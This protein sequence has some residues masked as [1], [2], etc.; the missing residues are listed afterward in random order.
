MPSRSAKRAPR[1]RSIEALQ[2][3][4]PEHRILLTGMTPTGREAGREVYGDRVI[5]AYLPY[6]YPDAVDRFFRH[7]SP[8]FG[9]L[10]ETEIWPNLL[11]AAK[12]K[13]VPVIL[14]NARLSERSARGYG[15]VTALAASGLFGARVPW[16]RRRPVD[17]RRIAELGAI[18]VNVCGNLKFDVTPAPEKIALGQAW[19]QAL[20][21][22][23]GLARRQHPR[24]RRSTGARGVAQALPPAV[25]CRFRCWSLCRAT[26]NAFAEVA[27]LL[28]QRRYRLRAA[29]RR[30]A[31]QR[32]AGL[33]GRQHG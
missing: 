23:A 6:D 3:A 29:Q 1:S 25:H 17:A 5:Q 2:E 26:R 27:A 16:P 31:G 12:R 14:A 24:G 18:N 4:W 8:A 10:M 7:F 22:A 32:D 28:A 30:L 9:V 19:R 11:A 13:G 20:G 15:K 21:C 33:A